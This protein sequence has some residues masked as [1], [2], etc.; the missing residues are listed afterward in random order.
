MKI[1]I[2][3]KLE[4][5]KVSIIQS[6]KKSSESTEVLVKEHVMTYTSVKSNNQTLPDNVTGINN[7]AEIKEA[8][9]PVLM[10]S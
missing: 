9:F 5:L 7:V 3:N 8:Y 10:V 6:L 4:D 1:R 2:E